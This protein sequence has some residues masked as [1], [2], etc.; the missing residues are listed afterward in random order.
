MKWWQKHQANGK[1]DITLVGRRVTVVANGKAIIVDQIIP[2]ITGGA[3]NSK[4]GEPR[5]NY[6]TR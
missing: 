6:V 5:S 3:L 1:Y 4:E 2:G